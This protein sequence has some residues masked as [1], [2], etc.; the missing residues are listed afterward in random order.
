[1]SQ[2]H[3]PQPTSQSAAPAEVFDS[4]A[5]APHPNSVSAVGTGDPNTAEGWRHAGQKN[6][7][8]IVIHRQFI[9]IDNFIWTS[10]MKRGHLLWYTAVHPSRC[11]P[12]ID[13]LSKIYNTWE[14]GFEFNFKV[15]GTGF[16]AGALAFVRIPPNRHPSE[17]KSPSEWGTFEYV[18]IDPKTLEVM[19]A[20]IMDQRR[21]FYHYMQLDFDDPDSFGGYMAC[22]VL[23]DLNTSSTGTQQITVQAF[24][25]PGPKFSM[26][27]L[28]PPST[29]SNPTPNAL[30]S[31]FLDA[32]SPRM[33]DVG[34]RTRMDMHVLMGAPEDSIPLHSM[35]GLDGKAAIPDDILNKHILEGEN[36]FTT[37]A[38]NDTWKLPTA[39][40]FSAK[41]E[42]V[43][44][45]A[46]TVTLYSDIC[47]YNGA[48]GI[49]DSV[50]LY[51]KNSGGVQTFTVF[52][53]R[54]LKF[55]KVTDKYKGFILKLSSTSTS[56]PSAGTICGV[57]S[58]TGQMKL[59]KVPVEPK[60][61]FTPPTGEHPLVYRNSMG[62]GEVTQVWDTQIDT[63]V[64]TLLQY[65][66]SQAVPQGMTAH[67]SMSDAKTNATL[68]EVKLYRNGAMTIPK[69]MSKM[70]FHNIQFHFIGL[71]PETVPLESK[72]DHQINAMTHSLAYSQQQN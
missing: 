20:E 69:S 19:T 29:S 17:F 36:L 66:L 8:D 23:M 13:H 31:T 22:Y 2:Q 44:T 32:L 68:G 52:A 56:F 39:S 38:W 46:K 67:L 26:D 45:G 37:T 49:D 28:I 53:L 55:D 54:S 47:I 25:R 27:Q 65:D 58:L 42:S 48:I 50:A 61:Y 30:P 7:F 3:I 70:K 16:H 9:P 72:A 18:V 62:T 71:I 14:G 41:V 64:R 5:V 12:L 59:E 6:T 40:G 43:D 11:N 33:G 1:M 21:F 60:E 24:C 57:S 51:Y 15:A 10:S 35:V 34:F 4:T 63:V